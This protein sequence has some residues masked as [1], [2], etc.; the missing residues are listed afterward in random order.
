M[1]IV[2]NPRASDSHRRSALADT[3]GCAPMPV[4][5]LVGVRAAHGHRGRRPVRRLLEIMQLQ[6]LLS[7]AALAA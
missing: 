3:R 2:I 7:A 5:A 1:N 6:P 4:P